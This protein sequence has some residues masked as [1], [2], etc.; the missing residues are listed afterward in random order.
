MPEKIVLGISA[1]VAAVLS[2]ILAMWAKFSFAKRS[3]MFRPDGQ[4]IYQRSV[5][6]R[7]YQSLCAE[8]MSKQIS[9][10]K[11]GQQDVRRELFSIGKSISRIEQ[12]MVDKN[13]H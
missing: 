7:T 6:C 10:L 4:P 2:T 12:W 1:G 11:T 9:E 3:E 5:D 8:R 13:N